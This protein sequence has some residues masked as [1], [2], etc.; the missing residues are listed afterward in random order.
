MKGLD[1]SAGVLRTQTYDARQLMQV[2]LL[3]SIMFTAKL[4]LEAGAEGVSLALTCERK[5]ARPEVATL[6]K[7]LPAA[8]R[9]WGAPSLRKKLARHGQGDV[10]SNVYISLTSVDPSS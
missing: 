2:G 4:A 7:R 3:R 8:L 5:L 10:Q 1:Y 9:F 6:G